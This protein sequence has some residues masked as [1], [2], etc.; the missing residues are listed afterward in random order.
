MSDVISLLKDRLVKAEARVQRYEK[1][2]ETARNE[3]S[4][5]QTTLRVL[6]EI[7][8]ESLAV[9]TV[10]SSQTPTTHRQETI[11]E[12]LGLGHEN[13]QSPG[14]VFEAYQRLG[15]DEINIDTFR[16]TIWR[17]K[18]KEYTINDVPYRVES[19]DGR[20]W[21]VDVSKIEPNSEN[22][23]GRILG[24]QRQEENAPEDGIEAI[25]GADLARQAPNEE[26]TEW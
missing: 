9:S 18:G 2:L 6:G 24:K 1:A 16:T 8:G 17:M 22:D 26:I 3:L 7:Q 4:D 12:L 13:G 19:G 25:F 14:D 21:K 23:L 15:G 20:Y 11:A 5:V 10:P